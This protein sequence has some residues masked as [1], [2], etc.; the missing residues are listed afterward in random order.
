MLLFLLLPP[1]G[2]PYIYG[3]SIRC[4]EGY[5][6]T[7]PSLPYQMTR[8]V[9]VGVALM[10]GDMYVAYFRDLF[11]YKML[12]AVCIRSVFHFMYIYALP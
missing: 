4:G 10:E 8:V 2:R 3:T 1:A 9:M 12:N 11:L 5:Y 7:I 6:H